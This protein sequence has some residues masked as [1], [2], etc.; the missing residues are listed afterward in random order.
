[1]YFN[2][3]KYIQPYRWSKEEESCTKFSQSVAVLDN[4]KGNLNW[5][6]KTRTGLNITCSLLL[7]VGNENCLALESNKYC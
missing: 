7:E 6:M 1:M 2:V 4:F 5:M 3:N